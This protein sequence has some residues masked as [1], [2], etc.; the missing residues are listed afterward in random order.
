MQKL[1]SSPG[2][3]TPLGV[4]LQGTGLNF[5]IFS[6]HAT[7]VTL[8]LFESGNLQPFFQVQL[9]ADTHR[10]GWIWH[11]Q[12]FGLQTHE[13]EYAYQ[14]E[15]SNQDPKNCFKP[16]IL[17]SD[18]YAK[19]LNTPSKWGSH[20]LESVK[21]KVIIDPPFD[22]EDSAPPRI[23]SEELI[24]YE[25]HLKAFT[26]HPSSGVEHKGTYLGM[27]EKIPYLKDLGVNA[28]E[29]LPIF[30]FDEC[31][32]PRINPM[33]G[34]KLK[35]FWGYSTI[36][37]FTPM[38]RYAACPNW[39]G[40][41]D[42][43]RTLVRELHKNG[44]EVILDVVYNHTAEGPLGG[45]DFSFRAID[46]QVYYCLD[47]SG[48][49]LDFTGT[50]NTFN[51]SHP[52]VTRL[53]TDSLHYWVTKMHIDG[54]RFDLAS[55]LTRDETGQPLLL[56]PLI[57]LLSHDPLLKDVK[58]IAEAWD[59]AGL[60]QVGSFPGEGRW[61]EWNGIYRDN[62]RRF[63]KGTDGYAGPFASA[64]CGS[65][66]L[67]GKSLKPYQSINFITAHDGFTMHDLVS[68]QTKHNLNNAESNRDGL[69]ENDNWNCGTEGLT[70]DPKITQLRL[71][72][73]KNM[74]TAL[75]LS[76]GTPMLL[77]GDEYGHTRY[78]NN[79]SYCQDNALNYFLWD[80]LKKNAAYARFHRLVIHFRKQHKL[81][82]R[83]RY[84]TNT[85]VDW[86][87]QKPMRPN[88]GNDNRLVAYTLKDDTEPLYIAFNAHYKALLLE[89]PSPPK[90]KQ[91][92]SVIQTALPSPDDFNENPQH[93]PPLAT[94]TIPPHST[95][96]A[97]AFPF[98][99]V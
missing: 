83:T 44:I 13:I 37:F 63:I 91:W 46:N 78:G 21:G 23:P 53:I 68:Y 79:N 66:N 89:L 92:H 99:T 86:H 18:P 75:M 11:I 76:I 71:Q 82:Q 5:A 80:E 39:S 35:N 12:L 60:Y 32:N 48:K 64:L 54:F 93:A 74:H 10:T 77:M 27:I 84:L 59:A 14:V 87:G 51:A 90:G 81:L 52:L 73:M 70:N 19:G 65:E 47:P 97:K 15:G 43:L 6:K 57:H 3:P 16:D 45:P 40:A 1:E 31:A 49:Y 41:I 8:F 4:S 30:E 96:V 69:S 85:E 36:N 42:E 98:T 88:W 50:G 56:P 24:I 25:M 20:P 34:E 72:Q 29:L 2:T 17:V 67:Y 22:W 61:S 95:L 28:V 33:T 9:D 26:E 58:L 94:Y 38:L 62:V 7:K 55:C